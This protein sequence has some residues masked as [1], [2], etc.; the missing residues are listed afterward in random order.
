MM[1]IFLAGYFAR[2][3]AEWAFTRLIHM[4]HVPVWPKKY[5][6]ICDCQERT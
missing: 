1:L 6:V 5:R 3:I 2:D 4:P